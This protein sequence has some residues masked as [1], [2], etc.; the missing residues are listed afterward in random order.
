MAG[1]TT[2]RTRRVTTH[3]LVY[4]TSPSPTGPFT[5]RGQFLYAGRS[6]G[7]RTI[8]IVEHGGRWWLYYHDASLSGGVS[9][10]AFA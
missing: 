10:E 3:L 7:R 9:S 4:A 8:S 1:S 2:C 5:F 6:A